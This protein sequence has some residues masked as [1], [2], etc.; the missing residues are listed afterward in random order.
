MQELHFGMWWCYFITHRHCVGVVYLLKEIF[1][2]FC[3][4]SELWRF[5][6]ESK[7]HRLFQCM[8]CIYL[9]FSSGPFPSPRPSISSFVFCMSPMM[10]KKFFAAFYAAWVLFIYHISVPINQE[11][12]CG[13]NLPSSRSKPVLFPMPGVQL[14]IIGTILTG[15]SGAPQALQKTLI[16]DGWTIL[17]VDYWSDSKFATTVHKEYGEF[18]LCSVFYMKSFKPF[19]W[20]QKIRID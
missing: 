4:V 19:T 20:N 10:Q 2:I 18:L 9:T 17:T 15:R 13:E 14:G 5:R 12:D 16:Y 8:L 6:I 3:I 7:R 1:K 11:W